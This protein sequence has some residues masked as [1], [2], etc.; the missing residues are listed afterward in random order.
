[1]RNL[2]RFLVVLV[3]LTSAGAVAL[4]QGTIGTVGPTV[5]VASPIE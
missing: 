4:A 2:L 1:M 3:F 5:V